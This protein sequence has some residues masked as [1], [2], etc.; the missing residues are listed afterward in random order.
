MTG[1]SLDKTTATVAA[2]A[3][4]QLTATVAPEDAANKAVSFTTSDAEVAL[5]DPS[6][7]ITGKKAGTAKVT[8]TTVDG[9]K[10]ATCDVTV[11]E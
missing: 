10:T 9:H 7:K 8:V 3:S 11:T 4:V 2:D 6:G 1:V 5:V